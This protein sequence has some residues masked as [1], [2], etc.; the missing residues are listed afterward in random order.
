MILYPLLS[1]SDR[2]ER[3][4]GMFIYSINGLAIETGHRVSDHV[5]C[6]E[7]LAALTRRHTST[8]RKK[9]HFDIHHLFK[10]ILTSTL[11]DSVGD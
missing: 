6:H 5:I 8:V 10:G 4:L 7:H 11:H 9:H 2:F 1:N 3:Y